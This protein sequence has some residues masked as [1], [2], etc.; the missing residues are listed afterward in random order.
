MW[1]G[2][3]P[4]FL[5]AVGSKIGPPS[6]AAD[7]AEADGAAARKRRKGGSRLLNLG[8]DGM[9]SEANA[10]LRRCAVGGDD[11]DCRMHG[12]RVTGE[13]RNSRG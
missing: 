5:P 3:A 13:A 10:L 12:D 7:D 8:A 1:V 4:F 2:V 9:D 11:E 6:A